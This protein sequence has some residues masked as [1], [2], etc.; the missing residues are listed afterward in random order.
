MTQPPII[1]KSSTG[2]DFLAS[3]P[4]LAG[5]TARD[6]LLIVPFRGK[7]TLGVIRT[8]LP[9]RDEPRA[10][11]RLGSLALGMLSRLQGCDGAVLV[12]Y[13]DETFPVARVAW[14]SLRSELDRRL[15]GAGFRVK[16]AFCVATDGWSSWFDTEAPVGGHP[17]S[18]I[19]ASPV[20]AEAAVALD[21]ERLQTFDAQAALPEPDPA[22]AELL[23]TAV[24]DLVELGQKRTA[25]GVHVEAEPP[26]AVEF[27]E[28]LLLLEP[29]TSAIPMLAQ[30][31]AF[32]SV[33]ATRD[34]LTLQIAFGAKEGRRAA[35]L[36]ARLHTLRAR[37]GLTMDEVVAREQ[38]AGRLRHDR[39]GDLLLGE[40]TRIPDAERIRTAI[41]ML[42]HSI[43]H[44]D[45]ADRVG[46]LCVLAWLNWA[47]GRA[48]V[49]HAHI[50]MAASIDPSHR[51]A[52]ILTMLFGSGKLPEWVYTGRSVE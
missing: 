19:E 28:R 45:P 44:V 39:S 22:L 15:E 14:N 49:A 11:E 17:L 6:S 5:Y 4:A 7:R 37:T 27:V 48:S 12:V 25:L 31:I 8:D 33:P 26:D 13:T 16:D 42:R 18:A 43:A 24:I 50:S 29:S 38:R 3:L 21:G 35:K 9:R 41:A 32:C 36:N 23:A 10:A 52:R 40:T 34:Q 47:L 20:A 2:A 51:M 46:P 1:L 30:L